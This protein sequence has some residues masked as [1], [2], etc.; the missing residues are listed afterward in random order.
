MAKKQTL[1][2]ILIESKN[3]HDEKLI[4]A[5][6]VQ[7]EVTKQ[8][9]DGKWATIEKQD[10]STEVVT[11]DDLDEEDKELMSDWG[12]LKGDG[13]TSKPN[14]VTATKSSTTK[15][16]AKKFEKVTSVTCTSK[17]KGG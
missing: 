2:P 15:S 11:A 1:V 16:I 9:Q 5:D 17:A 12:G 13:G 14:P 4:P 6:Q 8:V 3:G 7:E 10:G